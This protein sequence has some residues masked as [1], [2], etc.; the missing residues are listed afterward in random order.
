MILKKRD[1]HPANDSQIQTSTGRVIAFNKSLSTASLNT[2]KTW[3]RK[4]RFY[5]IAKNEIFFVPKT[6]KNNLKIRK[7]QKEIIMIN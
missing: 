6:R 5:H 7:D 2:N 4:W 1:S 3:L